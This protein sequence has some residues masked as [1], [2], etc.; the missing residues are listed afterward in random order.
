MASQRN[1]PRVV[2]IGGGFAG[3]Y[4]AKRLAGEPFDIV[5]ADKRN[6]HLFQ[7]LLYQVA[8]GGL[9][10]GDIC[11]PL[12]GVFSR[13]K[14]IRVILDEMTDLNPRERTVD[15]KNQR[16]MYDSLIV[17]AG[18]RH[19]Y[20]GKNDWERPA[21]GLKTV[22]DALEIRRRVFTAFESA[23]TEQDEEARRG[24]MSFA[25]I[26]GGPTGVELAGALAEL[27][28]QT[29][30]EDFRSINPAKTQITLIEGGGDILSAFDP[31]LRRKALTQL[32][33]LGV[34]VRT[35]AKVC[36]I[37]DRSVVL[38][39]SEGEE[40]LNA[41]TALWAA[42]V[43]ASP[44]GG[45]LASRA[46]ASL[47]EGGRVKVAADFSIPGW[48][49]IFVV[50]D[51][52][53]QEGADGRPL[54][55]LAPVAMQE[56]QY[57][58]QLLKAKQTGK[59]T[60]P[61]QYKDRGMLAVIGRRAAVAQLGAFRLSGFWAWLVW[62]FVHILYLIEFDNKAIVLFQWTWHY[63]TRNRGD[64]LITDTAYP[65]REKNGSPPQ[66]QRP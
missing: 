56:G 66:A 57:V 5:L 21:P 44:V 8:T 58:A 54:P 34:T 23:E 37:G 27:A 17:A 13:A 7:P 55:G 15:L 61:F 19:H 43:A 1:S 22:E 41:N 30:R 14:N 11:S 33:R 3:L 38:E 36:S 9:A 50:G 45:M 46:G 64:R 53:R 47:D 65:D 35:G 63:F 62:I 49:E 20:F 25:V 12:R 4:C 39:T 24:W 10:P 59:S 60:P 48:P 31:A 42:G 40:T 52:A 28:H 2:I 51:L 16:L 6:F 26:G 32:E 29:L 18:A